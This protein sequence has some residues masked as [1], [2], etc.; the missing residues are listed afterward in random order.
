MASSASSDAERIPSDIE[1]K[2][3][4]DNLSTLWQRR[5]EAGPDSSKAISFDFHNPEN[6]TKAYTI[7]SRDRPDEEL[8]DDAGGVEAARIDDESRRS[9]ACP[10]SSATDIPLAEA[11]LLTGNEHNA[12]RARYWS[13]MVALASSLI[14]GA[15]IVTGALILGNRS[16]SS[17]S[18]PADSQ[19]V[20]ST[21]IGDSDEYFTTTLTSATDGA[22]SSVVSPTPLID[23]TI[24]E[25]AESSAT[26]AIPPTVTSS[27]DA[28]TGGTSG[29]N[30]STTSTVSL[31]ATHPSFERFTSRF[32]L[33]SAISDYIEGGGLLTLTSS[34]QYGYPIG[35]W[36][37]SQV[38]DMSALFMDCSQYC[39]G[40]GDHLD[41]STFNESLSEWNT[42][43]VTK[44]LCHQN[45]QYVP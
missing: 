14:V 26:S 13:A 23:P 11:T 42:S 3:Q 36:D 8:H 19:L 31:P 33:R 41:T 20:S 4:A 40:N 18:P 1:Y 27:Q 15:A 6:Y 32:Q 29:S 34:Q 43:S 7:T 16:S 35:A 38:T 24:T 45:E 9:C 22:P 25:L 28:G 30:E 10:V 39:Y 21:D 37:V 5:N 2:E 17:S 44:I 12:Q